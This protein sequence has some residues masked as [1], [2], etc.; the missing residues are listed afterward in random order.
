MLALTTFFVCG[1]LTLILFP[2][3]S[4]QNVILW[5]SPVDL[6]YVHGYNR[7][8]VLSLPNPSPAPTSLPGPR[9]LQAG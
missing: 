3:L 9:P 4:A 5:P 7:P 6:N 2:L 1:F 8:S